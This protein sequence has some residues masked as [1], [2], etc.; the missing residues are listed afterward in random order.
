MLFLKLFYTSYL[1]KD[2]VLSDSFTIIEEVKI[3]FMWAC[4]ISELTLQQKILSLLHA[5]PEIS[6]AGSELVSVRPTNRFRWNIPRYVL[7]KKWVTCSDLVVWR[8]LQVTMLQR[9]NHLDLL[10]NTVP[11]SSNAPNDNL[12]KRSS[13]SCPNLR[14]HSLQLSSRPSQIF[15][16][17]SNSRVGRWATVFQC[18]LNQIKLM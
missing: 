9:D 14:K 18:L 8:N 5:G 17:G 12:Y 16:I 10:L 3:C 13:L 7:L 11:R 2:L 15:N 6:S 1:N 4:G